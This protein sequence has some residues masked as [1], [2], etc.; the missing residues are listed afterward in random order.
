MSLDNQ[1]IKDVGTTALNWV[2]GENSKNTFTT[3]FTSFF[4]MLA[5]FF[6]T[7]DRAVKKQLEETARDLIAETTS[8]MSGGVLKAVMKDNPKIDYDSLP[9]G[10]NISGQSADKLREIVNAVIKDMSS[11]PELMAA[12]IKDGKIN[13]EDI[14]YI[15]GL[16]ISPLSK[17]LQELVRNGGISKDDIRGIS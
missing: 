11:N 9:V 1:E 2:T 12:I 3:I 13:Y 6:G 7:S 8:G 17:N 14:P 4:E 5:G 10:F 15:Q 16:A